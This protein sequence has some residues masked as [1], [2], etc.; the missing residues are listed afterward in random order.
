M[1]GGEKMASQE[2]IKNLKVFSKKL[3]SFVDV[4]SS[5]NKLITFMTSASWLDR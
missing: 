5:E 3:N 4:F 1:K 2:G